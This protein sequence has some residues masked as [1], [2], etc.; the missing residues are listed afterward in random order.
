MSHELEDGIEALEGLTVDR[1]LLLK[2]GL[3]AAGATLL[4][5]PA[6]AF[7]ASRSGKAA[8]AGSVKI[9]V[10]THGD[11]GAFWSV[12]KH[13]VDQAHKDLAAR[14]VKVTSQVYANNA[15]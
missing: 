2:G 13:G 1:R 5:S 6:A 7:A 4:G 12:F 9:A 8:A 15:V 3:A 11:T 14:G 10:I